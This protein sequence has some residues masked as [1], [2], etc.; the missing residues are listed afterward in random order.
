METIAAERREAL[1]KT[2]VLKIQKCENEKHFRINVYT[3]EMKTRDTKQYEVNFALTERP[4][5]SPVRYMQ[6]LLNQL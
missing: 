5:K 2:I 6:K 1:C 4:R 3:H